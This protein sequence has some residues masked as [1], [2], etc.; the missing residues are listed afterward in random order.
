MTDI[1]ENC[2]TLENDRWLLR[3]VEEGDAED[4]LSVYSDKMAL[5]FFNSDN[6]HGDIFYYPTAERMARAVKFWIDSYAWRYFVRFTIIDKRTG[7]A[8][9]TIEMFNRSGSDATG[10]AGVLRLDVGS[11]W[12]RA[13]VLS[14]LLGLVIGPFFAWFRVDEILIKGPV[15]AVERAL[16]LEERGFARTDQPLIGEG[17]RAYGGYWTIRLN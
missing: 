14:E 9:G 5:P 12:E 4:L 10:G 15:Y 1:Y 6:C 2:P 3:L 11:A 7:R 16:A 17:G 13:D 8:I